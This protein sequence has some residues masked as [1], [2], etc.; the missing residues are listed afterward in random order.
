MRLFPWSASLAALLLALG[1]SPLLA[2]AFLTRASPPV[3]STI[4]KAPAEVTL[5]FTER[6]EPAFSTIEVSG[7]SGERVDD[8][9]TKVSKEEPTVMRTSLKPISPGTY[10]VVW[11]VTSVDSHKTNGDFTFSLAP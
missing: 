3:G 7:P 6:I 9:G 8:G 11:R 5:R 2:H 4:R 10:K 1:A